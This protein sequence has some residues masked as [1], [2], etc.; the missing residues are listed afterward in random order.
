MADKRVVVVGAGMAGLVAALRL[1]H[2]GLQVTVIERSQVAG[3]KIRAQEIDGQFID[4][5][6]TVFTMKWVFA[7]LMASVGTDLDRE[8][9]LSQ[10]SVIGRHFWDDGSA[11]DL[12]ADAKASEAAVEMF[13]GAAE[14]ERF[15]K[16]CEMTS[17]LYKHLEA[18]FIRSQVKNLPRFMLSLGPK[19][20]ALMASVGPTRTMWDSLGRHFSDPRLRQLFGRYAT[21][22]GSSPWQAPATLNL[23]AQ[24]EMDGVWS[25]QGGM[26]ALAQCLVRLCK[27]NGVQFKYNTECQEILVKDGKAVGVLLPDGEVE[28]ADVVIFNG[29]AAALRQGLL[30]EKT[31]RAVPPRTGQRSLSAV[32]WCVSAKARGI[33]LDR[34]NLFFG[35]DYASEFNDIFTRKRLPE[36]PTLYVCAQ[37]RGTGLDFEGPERMLCLVNAPAVGD[38]D[39]G[40]LAPEFLDKLQERSFQRA[41]D[42]GL[43]M[44]LETQHVVRSTPRQFHQRFPGT[45]GALYGQATH[46]WLSIFSRPGSISPIPG[47]YLAGGSVHPGPGVPMAAMSGRLAAEAI[48]ENLGLTSRFHM[49]GTS[50]GT[51]MQ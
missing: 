24:V 1:A 46:G 6:P 15:R 36:D 33:K 4:A 35:R 32:T 49:E 39:D 43:Q 42:C 21:Y 19:G 22:C 9:Q 29:D 27:Q 30:G 23:I 48:M 40:A 18:P 41:K 17:A 50:G 13:A 38:D 25:V 10:L 7:E 47:L 26:T 34:H 12:F 44:S 5:G 51:S 31:C 14:A 28:K 2:Q 37:D 16:F 45:G 8:L 11:L 20:L 3:G